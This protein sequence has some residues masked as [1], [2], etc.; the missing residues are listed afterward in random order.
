[1]ENKIWMG[2]GSL[3]LVIMS[4][5]IV[6]NWPSTGLSIEIDQSK[7]VFK[8]NSSGNLIVAGQENNYL[9]NGSKS[10]AVLKKYNL[11]QEMIGNDLV[12]TRIVD[13]KSGTRIID[14]YVF[15]PNNTDIEMFPVS[16]SIQVINGAGLTYQYQVSKLSYDGKSRNA[17]NPESF[18]NNMKVEWQDGAYSQKISKT[19]TDTKLVVK[20][21][22]VSDSEVYKV[23]LFDP[24][25]QSF[26]NSPVLCYQESAN[27][28]NQ[29]GIDSNCTSLNY[30]GSYTAAG[31]SCPGP[32]PYASL[33]SS[34]VKPLGALNMIWQVKHG[35]SSTTAYNIS[36]PS[37]CF[38][39]NRTHVNLM[40]ES[41]FDGTCGSSPKNYTSQPKCYNGT[42]WMNIGNTRTSN[43]SNEY[44]LVDSSA[45]LYDGNWATQASWEFQWNG[46]TGSQDTAHKI[47]EEAAIWNVSYYV[48]NRTNFSSTANICFQ[49][50]ANVSTPCGGASTGW[51][52]IEGNA[53]STPINSVGL[54]FDSNWSSFVS[55]NT[56][57]DAQMGYYANYVIPVGATNDSTFVF[58][59]PTTPTITELDIPISCWDYDYA[60]ILTFY[61]VSR[62]NTTGNFWWHNVSCYNGTGLMLMYN[63]TS[64]NSV[65]DDM[66][67]EAMMWR[68]SP[69]N[70][71]LSSSNTVIADVATANIIA[72]I[73]GYLDI[74]AGTRRT[75]IIYY[76]G[77]RST[78]GNT[79]CKN[80]TID[81]LNNPN[82][83]T[84]Y[85][86]TGTAG[87]PSIEAYYL[88]EESLSSY[89]LGRHNITCYLNQSGGVIA[90][91]AE[92][93]TVL[94]NDTD[95]TP[96]R[97]TLDDQYSFAQGNNLFYNQDA[98]Y[99][100][101]RYVLSFFT[102]SAS[103]YF[104]SEINS[105]TLSR[106]YGRQLNNSASQIYY[107][108]LTNDSFNGYAMMNYSLIGTGVI[109]PI[110]SNIIVYKYAN[111]S[112]YDVNKY[113][114][115]KNINISLLQRNEVAS[116]TSF[117]C[118]FSYMGRYGDTLLIYTLGTKVGNFTQNSTVIKDFTGTNYN[119]TP[120]LNMTANVTIG[121]YIHNF[122]KY[123]PIPGVLYSNLTAVFNDSVSVGSCSI[124]LLSGVSL[125]NNSNIAMN[126]FPTA[127]IY[128]LNYTQLPFTINNNQNSIL[129]FGLGSTSGIN[130]QT[131]FVNSTAQLILS[132]VAYENVYLNNLP[133]NMNK[134][135]MSLKYDTGTTN[136]RSVV[137]QFE[138]T[139]DVNTGKFVYISP[140]PADNTISNFINNFTVNITFFD[141]TSITNTTFNL[142]RTNYS[143]INNTIL[144]NITEISFFNETY[145]PVFDV[146]TSNIVNCTQE[147][148][149]KPN[150]TNNAYCSVGSG[151]YSAN[152]SG[153]TAIS[154]YLL[155]IDGNYATLSN[156]STA[157]DY[158]IQDVT[159]YKPLRYSNL[160]YWRVYAPMPIGTVVYTNFTL[161]NLSTY[162]CNINPLQFR[163]L[164][165]IDGAGTTR[166]KN[167][168][169]YNGTGYYVFSVSS[170]VDATANDIYEETMI[171]INTDNITGTYY[172]LQN[173]TRISLNVINL[174]TKAPYN[175]GFIINNTYSD[176]TS[177]LGFSP[178]R[179]YY[180]LYGIDRFIN[181]TQ[182][183]TPL[184]IITNISY[185]N[186]A[187]NKL[188]QP[189]VL[190]NQSNASKPIFTVN[191][192]YNTSV[193]IEFNATY[194]SDM[195]IKCSTE[196]NVSNA[197]TAV[198]EYINITDNVSVG[199]IKQVWC[200]VDVNATK[201]VPLNISIRG[202]T[203]DI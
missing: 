70:F 185:Y 180:W 136:V 9:Y 12:I 174:T 119:L 116:G 3:I 196:F 80:I 170:N 197:I 65:S 133:T 43:N 139:P 52:T 7:S 172:G 118:N 111:K 17:V 134:T 82:L 194:S 177:A 163:M 152:L 85:A 122:Y 115:N 23:K 16:H 5:L 103:T 189:N 27:T 53:F 95:S 48:P 88:S 114:Y 124:Y 18:G 71:E 67:E 59:K 57:G 131:T 39:Y 102:L 22:I 184:K 161:A 149:N 79:S 159:Y 156:P 188:V 51:Y 130:A 55:L 54:A 201:T 28:F 160:S 123:T 127:G 60:H 89:S 164:S 68:K 61:E 179:I 192:S 137:A 44:N 203:H 191:N 186:W 113:N 1:M 83:T 45:N 94:I 121:Y 155:A 10:V 50:Q 86:R 187:T 154:T 69:V 173:I 47:Y 32:S 141:F 58:S 98:P 190:F 109:S 11:T 21:K 78:A 13:Y 138:L 41:K 175:Y 165:G 158:I 162:G 147:F 199:T 107:S 19:A 14:I 8:V 36:V 181:V 31:G 42:D 72:N 6:I 100:R 77:I 2:I 90:R 81:N 120:I 144:Q 110:I 129:T 182:N 25:P 132:S 125:N 128:T 169:C 178:Q 35:N 117:S 140:T 108:Y 202:V 97:Y 200:W 105:N 63:L 76:Q 34:Y 198:G 143:I 73:T 66:Y 46:A 20:Y 171:W 56:S 29:T 49:E 145:Y 24:A 93:N 157:G 33:T 84:I 183:I 148:A 153:A 62:K 106:L 101:N 146:N 168:S 92:I 104:V 26:F 126:I 96:P 40:I 87:Q 167:L 15:N 91:R 195:K 38:N 166:Y 176:N 30:S 4:T 142:Y 135:L 112:L 193:W 37:L 151:F 75:A 64:T 74:V 99:V 150:I